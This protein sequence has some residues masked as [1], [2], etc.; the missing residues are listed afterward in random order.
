MLAIN[1]AEGNILWQFATT[2]SPWAIPVYKDGVVYVGDLSNKA[3]AISSS[4]GK[5]VW[6]VDVPGP[7]ASSPAI[8][9]KG[10]IFASET[11]DVFELSFSGQQNWDQKLSG[12]NGK[13]Y[14]AP[15]VAGDLVVVG[16]TAGDNNLLL[17]SYDFS[18]AQKWTFSVPK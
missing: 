10:L 14:S 7:I 1:A 16:V 11:G 5:Q 12:N 6:Q 18:G 13:L 17:V 4:D 15:V 9:S 8:T 3:Y 2:G